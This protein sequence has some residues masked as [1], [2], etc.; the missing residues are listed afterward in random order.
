[1]PTNVVWKRLAIVL[2]IIATVAGLA[3]VVLTLLARSPERRVA[4]LLEEA[5]IYK[6]TGRPEKEGETL[7]RAL[8]AMPEDP[9]LMAKLARNLAARGL[10]ERAATLF[11]S[12]LEHNPDDIA[13]GFD[14]FGLLL[15]RGGLDEAAKLLD[16]LEGQAQV[17]A[18]EAY[19]DRVSTSR[20]ELAL[21]RGDRK[22]ALEC[23]RKALQVN[24]ALD[25]S[26]R[27]GL[28]GL[29]SEEGSAGEAEELARSL[30]NA[31]RPRGLPPAKTDEEK[32]REEATYCSDA[33]AAQAALLV[34]SL[35]ARRGAI[36]EA[37][38][39]LA[40]GWERD[41]SSVPVAEA[42][43]DAEAARGHFEQALAVATKLESAREKTSAAMVRG[44]VALVRNEKEAARRAFEEAVSW[45]PGLA[46]PALAAAQCALDAHDTKAAKALALSIDALKSTLDERVAISHVLQDVGEAKAAREQLDSVLA[47]AP[48]DP[49]AVD[50]LVRMELSAGKPDVASHE[51]DEL[52][53]RSPGNA[54]IERARTLLALWSSDAGK[55]VALS[56]KTLESGSDPSSLRI[57]SAALALEGGVGAAVKE[58]ERLSESA[59]DEG[60]RVR[61]RLQAA[62]LFRALER[63]DLAIPILEKGLSEHP[64]TPELRLALARTLLQARRPE[65]ASK[66]LAP[67][68]DGKGLPEA[69][70]LAASADQAR[71]DF[72]G[73]IALAERLESDPVHAV[74]AFAL[75]GFAQR[76]LGDLDAARSAFQHVRDLRPSVPL[77]YAGALSDLAARPAEAVAPL[78]KA[79]ELVESERFD[80][81][82]AVALDLASGADEALALARAA[83][84][85]S[86]KDA[87][88]AYLDA[89][90]LLRRGRSDDAAAVL[91]GAE[92]PPELGEALRELDRE[93]LG[94]FELLMELDRRGLTHEAA[95]A[96][97][98]LLAKDAGNAAAVLHAARAL[99]AA[100]QV[101]RAKEVLSRAVAFAP[102]CASCRLELGLLLEEAPGKGSSLTLLDEGLALAPQDTALELARGM[103]LTSLGRYAEAEVAY[104]KVI[105][106]EPRNAAARNNLAWSLLQRGTKEALDEAL[107]LARDVAE[108]SPSA[109]PALDTLA[110]V[111]LARG[112]STLALEGA[113]KAVELAPLDATI[114]LTFA[115]TL[116]ALGRAQDAANQYEVALLLS[117]SFDG[118]ADAERRLA[119]LRTP[120]GG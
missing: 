50:L 31:R 61:A 94:R 38:G 97:E 98:A 114:R 86:P 8:A 37:A 113:Q 92:V 76:S 40:E 90:I 104:R 118:R 17:V 88:A 99:A 28:A 83:L 120:K 43:A 60:V 4:R 52:A 78:R 111:E 14:Y 13:A 27:L 33:T 20:A 10:D 117:A 36:D 116:D 73:S 55:A 26:V 19:R 30:W 107:G 95:L 106:L 101:D 67:L 69:I 87:S 22:T 5:Q 25:S 74:E 16:R 34:G 57:L 68:L 9:G 45:S 32:L 80:L 77:G 96:A 47:M 41:P 1:M 49:G 21:R 71:S 110:R 79:C 58:L 112:E 53:K 48:G 12:S 3:A 39:V 89:A 59:A 6:R 23:L 91:A 18:Q 103:V 64:M 84:A 70:L 11:R 15:A 54:V 102:R 81:D 93:S 108:K 29:L 56:E 109:A 105:A 62:E 63:S 46:A 7:E 85:R 65:E 66:T 75:E 35:L 119:T 82:L 100:G 44:R 2:G 42:L 51:L 115:K 24:P 72:K